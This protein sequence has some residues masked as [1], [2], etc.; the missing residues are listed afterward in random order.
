MVNV[1]KD[2]ITGFERCGAV[3]LRKERERETEKKV[4]DRK[5]D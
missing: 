4:K 1:G 2:V 3:P 5:T